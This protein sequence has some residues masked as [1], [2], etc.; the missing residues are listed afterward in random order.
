MDG[1]SGSDLTLKAKNLATVA[2]LALDNSAYFSCDLHD[3][4]D[5]YVQN[6]LRILEHLFYNGLKTRGNLSKLRRSLH[7]W[8]LITSI[9]DTNCIDCVNCV[10]VMGHLKNEFG[11]LRLWIKIGLLKRRFHLLLATVQNSNDLLRSF[12]LPEAL[13]LSPGFT[14]VVEASKNLENANLILDLKGEDN[15]N[16]IH[17]VDYAFYLSN[18]RNS[19]VQI[20]PTS[21]CDCEQGESERLASSCHWMRDY[22]R[23]Q[24]TYENAIKQQQ[25]FEE[26][27][28]KKQ[29]ELDRSRTELAECKSL[30]R[31]LE[32][33][34]LE[35]QVQIALFHEQ[36]VRELKKA[37]VQEPNIRAP[38]VQQ[39]KAIGRRR[40]HLIRQAEL[41]TRK[42]SSL[43]ED[44]RDY[45][46]S[47]GPSSMSPT[48]P[49]IF[50]VDQG[51][52]ALSYSVSDG[53]THN[54]GSLS[55]I[56]IPNRPKSFYL[57]TKHSNNL[58][59]G[60]EPDVEDSGEHATT[61]RLNTTSST[62]SKPPTYPLSEGSSPASGSRPNSLRLR[63]VRRSMQLR[64]ANR[65][66]PLKL[67]NPI[68]FGLQKMPEDSTHL[69]LPA[70]AGFRPTGW[71][72]AE[73][74]ALPLTSETPS[75]S[76]ALKRGS[77]HRFFPLESSQSFTMIPRPK[78][79][80]TPDPYVPVLLRS[81]ARLLG[82]CARPAS[83]SALEHL[84]EERP[85]PTTKNISQ[86]DD[87]AQTDSTGGSEAMLHSDFSSRDLMHSSKEYYQLT[88]QS[89]E[90][91]GSDAEQAD[92][93]GPAISYGGV[94]SDADEGRTL[95]PYQKDKNSA[96][97][98][99]VSTTT[100]LSK[101]NVPS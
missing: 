10:Q 9:R 16:G 95:R 80:R 32:C 66:S 42:C 12:Y 82:S 44:R 3:E 30:N 71:S 92:R 94:C 88:S 74:S 27:L 98:N 41:D 63:K 54:T 67:K 85:T 46:H 70:T 36:C 64:S 50:S 14:P 31:D 8:N 48:M 25:H 75:D 47:H 87:K 60:Q 35:L 91:F 61:N 24:F 68:M 56:P 84:S 19:R 81:N 55:S 52:D 96:T 73:L 79:A 86:L 58:E 62:N 77:S 72:L 57:P 22:Q 97:D 37:G 76:S 26:L 18:C 99:M 53:F 93:K 78:W 21:N 13:L 20:P 2:C 6:L 34:V 7:P 51:M 4:K 65:S 45:L 38:T 59:V 39:W 11:K 40:Q 28:F 1:Y 43:I 90:D 33:D 29:N 5:A 23:L 15:Y 17:P 83:L 101:D 49:S 100:V 89:E 69:V